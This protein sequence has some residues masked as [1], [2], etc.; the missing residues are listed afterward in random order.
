M[1]RTVVSAVAVLLLVSCGSAADPDPEGPWTIVIVSD[2]FALGSWPERWAALIEEDLGVDVDLRNHQRSGFVDY[3]AVI[4][5]PE[6]RADLAEADIVLIPPEADHLRRAC[7]PDAGMA[8]VEPAAAEYAAAWGALLD[9]VRE[10]NPD[11]RLRSA[12]A[13]AWVA[14]PGRRDGLRVFMEAAAE[15]TRQH[16]GVVVDVDPIMTGPNRD[17]EP[18]EGWTDEYGHFMRGG[19][20]AVAEAFHAVGYDD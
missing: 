11:A 4:D 7:G 10:I 15:V 5:E 6:V 2:S 3:E 9:E 20:Q 18:P 1:R 12:I 16:G 8:C 19:A 14:P 17:E 13:W